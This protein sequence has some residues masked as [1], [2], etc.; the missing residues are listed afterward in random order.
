MLRHY[1]TILLNTIQYDSLNS[2]L[3]DVVFHMINMTFSSFIFNG[4]GQGILPHEDGPLYFPTV[5][6]ISLGS[7]AVLDFYRK[8]GRND[9]EADQDGDSPLQQRYISSVL[10]QVVIY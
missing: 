6:T 8:Q 3:L 10:V 7:H 1:K 5:T 4:S 9:D 2:C